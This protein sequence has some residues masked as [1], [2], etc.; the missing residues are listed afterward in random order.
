MTTGPSPEETSGWTASTRPH[1]TARGLASKLSRGDRRA[2]VHT[3]ALEAEGGRAVSILFDER[4][5]LLGAFREVRFEPSVAT[6]ERIRRQHA[7]IVEAVVSGRL[8]LP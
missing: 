2:Y 6:D 8:V 7:E 5:R 3:R 1:Q 4:G